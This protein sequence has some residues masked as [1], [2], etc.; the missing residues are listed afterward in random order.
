MEQMSTLATLLKRYRKGAGLTKAVLAERAGLS[1]VYFSMIEGRRRVP[2]SSTIEA[3]AAAL[4]L[5]AAQQTAI[6]VARRARQRRG[7]RLR[8]RLGRLS[9]GPHM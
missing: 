1:A 2:H 4:R 8:G 7:R 5:D 9:A 3:L 6:E